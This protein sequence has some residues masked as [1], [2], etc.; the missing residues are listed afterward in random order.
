MAEDLRT[1]SK[2]GLKCWAVDVQWVEKEVKTRK[3]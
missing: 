1:L 2:E 3:V